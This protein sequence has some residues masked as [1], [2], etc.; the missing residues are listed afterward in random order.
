M[1]RQVAGVYRAN[2]VIP[3]DYAE[4]GAE[5]NYYGYKWLNLTAGVYNSENLSK[6]AALGPDGQLLP[7]AD[8][9]ILSGLVKV[10]FWP[11][12][13][14]N[15]LNTQIGASYFFNGNYKVADF[16]LNLGLTDRLALLTEYVYS[17]KNGARTTDN[18][19]IELDYQYT[20]PLIAYLKYE[21]G[22][23][24]LYPD[25]GLSQAYVNNQY[26]V[27]LRGLS[28][29]FYGNQAGIQNF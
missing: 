15:Q 27:G 2:Q 14:E 11:R 21:K 9:D 19:M 24:G 16:F 17:Q 4:F 6:I 3:P 5:I 12:F 22:N 7:L 20:D 26:I 18:Y 8:K 1:I 28:A 10:E 29:A 13:F 23:T 25:S